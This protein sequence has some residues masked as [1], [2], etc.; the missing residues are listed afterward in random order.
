MNKQ[1]IKTMDFIRLYLLYMYEGGVNVRDD[2][3]IAANEK[4]EKL[5]K[6]IRE[7]EFGEIKVIIQEGVPIRVEEMKK[8][9]K[10]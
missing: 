3:K 8:S 5:L 6:L 4:E 1:D 9:I 2:K 7:T 10:L